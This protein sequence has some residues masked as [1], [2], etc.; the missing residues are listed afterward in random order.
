MQRKKS[1]ESHKDEDKSPDSSSWI[2]PS[3]QKRFLKIAK[4]KDI[5]RLN[6]WQAGYGALEDAL[7]R[8]KK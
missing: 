6:E 4:Q 1:E 3:G 5:N 8:A 2:T 7:K